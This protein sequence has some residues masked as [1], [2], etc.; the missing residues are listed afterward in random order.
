MPGTLLLPRGR[1][2]SGRHVSPDLT[3]P[4]EIG[5]GETL[6]VL[7]PGGFRE[8]RWG[9]IPTGRR[10]ARGRPVLDMLAHARGETLFN[11][12]VFAG[13]RRGAVP[14]ESWGDG[15]GAPGCRPTMEVRAATGGPLWLALVW[16]V[17][18]SPGGASLAQGALV[19]SAPEARLRDRLDRIAVAISPDDLP[20]WLSGTEDVAREM[21]ARAG[22]TPLA[23]REVAQDERD[24]WGSGAERGPSARRR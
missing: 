1:V 4:R 17:W 7:T 15:R 12:Q 19:T 13:A 21:I 24:G 23:V 16:D 2:T 18:Q 8:M 14:V 3:L 20:L 11:K 9:L 6:P 22:A 10:N 5:P